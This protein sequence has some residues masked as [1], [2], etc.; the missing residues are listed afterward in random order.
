MLHHQKTLSEILCS[1]MIRMKVFLPLILVLLGVSCA[2]RRPYLVTSKPEGTTFVRTYLSLVGNLSLGGEKLLNTS[3]GESDLSG[4]TP[5]LE[6]SLIG[7]V[8]FLLGNSI[9]M[10]DYKVGRKQVVR[11]GN[12][13]SLLTSDM[14]GQLY[15]PLSKNFQ[16]PIYVYAGYGFRSTRD[17][18]DHELLEQISY[19][20]GGTVN[21]GVMWTKNLVTLKTEAFYSNFRE[22][23]AYGLLL[24]LQ[25]HIGSI[26]L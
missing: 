6:G 5:T 11:S 22:F 20:K 16:L 25:V 18:A 17:Y 23:N 9:F 24:T 2:S 26:F 1:Q 19:Q 14:R 12:D 15:L 13:F 3:V 4:T 8:N 21:L 7:S 10:F